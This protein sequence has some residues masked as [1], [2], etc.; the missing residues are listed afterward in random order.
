MTLSDKLKAL[1]QEHAK[2]YDPAVTSARDATVPGKPLYVQDVEDRA[3]RQGKTP[4]QVRREDLEMLANSQFPSVQCLKPGELLLAASGHRDLR[5]SRW[6]HLDACP[7]CQ[8]LVANSGLDERFVA[9]MSRLLA[10]RPE[11]AEKV[12]SWRRQLARVP[13]R[14]FMFTAELVAP[15]ILVGVA[16]G[17]VVLANRLASPP[18]LEL[19]ATNL[20]AS[21]NAEALLPGALALAAFLL[22][23][24]AALRMAKWSVFDRFRRSGAVYA[25]IIIG[26]VAGG[27][28]WWDFGQRAR[29]AQVTI[30]L[31]S[32]RLAQVAAASM[33]V[34]DITGTFPK[35]EFSPGALE[36]ST[37]VN[38]PRRAIYSAQ[39]K[40]LKG[41]LVAD[42]R[43]DGGAVYWQREG[44]SLE[45]G[46]LVF[47][48]IHSVGPDGIVISEPDGTKT[49][50][51]A[52]RD[53]LRKPG[54]QVIAVVDP[55]TNAA[56]GVYPI[57]TV[58]TVIP[59]A[60][61]A[62]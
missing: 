24:S 49:T 60:A 44:K 38:T 9:E 13:T 10:Q 16:V 41:K 23:V 26:L 43:P 28:V 62:R 50:L 29:Q 4:A 39:A 40:G 14:A 48:T 46:R 6:T 11:E 25:G 19:M 55:R 53:P 58:T 20:R 36:F 51:K 7:Y 37:A 57:A 22:I 47:G 59:T 34:R 1:V 61:A 18:P 32:S 45:V 30:S 17:S 27:Y 3:K 54:E 35:V 52:L 42:I 56:A 2:K 21:V 8:V 33:D 12:A 5:E 31:V 15:I